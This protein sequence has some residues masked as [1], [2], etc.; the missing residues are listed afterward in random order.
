M[1]VDGTETSV[2]KVKVEVD[3]AKTI[4]ELQ[5]SYANS[6]CKGANRLNYQTKM[7]VKEESDYH[8]DYD[9]SLREATEEE[10]QNYKAFDFVAM[11][12]RQ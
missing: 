7:W 9:V 11:R 1:L 10:I 3:I 4:K 6:V 2:K 8:S 12:A 5:C